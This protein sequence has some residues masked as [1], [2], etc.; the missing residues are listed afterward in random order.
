MIV[1]EMNVIMS[2]I[3][4]N[5]IELVGQVMTVVGNPTV[6]MKASVNATRRRRREPIRAI[7]RTSFSSQVL[8]LLG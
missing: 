4:M 2:V 5:V 6:T 8:P 7:H 1:I 3:E